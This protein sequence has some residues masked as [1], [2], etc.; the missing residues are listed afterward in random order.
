[1]NL[2][3][4]ILIILLSPLAFLATAIVSWFQPGMRPILTKRMG[5]SSALLSII[6]AAISGFFVIKYGLLE[7][8]LLG[9]NNLGFSVR[10]DSVSMIMFSMIAVIAF[11]VMKFSLNYLDG[12]RNHGRFIGRLA[13]TIA[14]VQLLVLSGNLGLLLISWIL[15]SISLHRLLVFYHDRPGAISAARKKFIM[16]RLGD[17]CL[18]IAVSL[19][20][21]QFG[22]GNMETIFQQ[23]NLASLPV[24]VEAAAIALVFAA[25]FKSAQFPTHGW[26]IEVMETPTPVSALLHAGL[27]NAGPFLLIRM[28]FVMDASIYAPIFIITIGGFTAMFASLAFL[29]QTSVKTALG[30]S[31]VAHMGFSLMVCGL[32]VYPAAMLHLVAHSF[33]KAHSFL[34]SGSIIDSIRTSKVKMTKRTGSPIKIAAGFMLALGIYAAFALLWGIDPNKELALLAIGAIMVMGLSTLFTSALDSNGSFQLVIRASILALIVATSFFTLES[35]F[36]YLLAGQVP[37]LSGLSLTEMWLIGGVLL[38]FSMVVFFQ[39]LAP[40]FGTSQTYTAVAIHLRNGLYANAVLDR[41]IGSLR[42]PA[43]AHGSIAIEQLE[44][45]KRQESVTIEKLEK[46]V[47]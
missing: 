29:T 7:S 19:L 46:E 43:P 40:L 11:I 30:Y 22:T 21:A 1:M 4:I 28:A 14:S 33:Y 34:S 12:D 31:S 23:I 26:L 20:Y 13:A 17:L 9:V 38:A 10:L 47:I 36:H 2:D 32:G 42:I 15:T 24:N 18:L 3:F 8:S 44:M 5:I 35:G 39:I 45:N 41:I 16:A 6:T 27:L 37:D 25:L